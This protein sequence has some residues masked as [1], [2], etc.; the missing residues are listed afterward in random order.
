M[1]DSVS[2][3]FVKSLRMVDSVSVVFVKSL[4]RVVADPVS[5][6]RRGR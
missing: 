5:R 3:V 6:P 1:V 2:V 4:G